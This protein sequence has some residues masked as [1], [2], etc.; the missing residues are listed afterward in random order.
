[1]YQGLTELS[2]S[3][4]DEVLLGQVLGTTESGELTFSLLK[5]EVEVDP[6]EYL[7]QETTL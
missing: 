6:L 7:F 5:D 1:M 4:G 2:V 3:S